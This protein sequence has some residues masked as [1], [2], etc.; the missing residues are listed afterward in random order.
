MDRSAEGSC[1][2][3]EWTSLIIRASHLAQVPSIDPAFVGVDL[4]KIIDLE[5]LIQWWNQVERTS[6]RFATSKPDRELQDL[7]CALWV[8]INQVHWKPLLRFNDIRR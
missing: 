5:M 6:E 4:F 7:S 1:M 3:I 2:R 8:R